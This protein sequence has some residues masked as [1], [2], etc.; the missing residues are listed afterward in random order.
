MLVPTYNWTMISDN[1]DPVTW[2]RFRNIDMEIFYWEQFDIFMVM[3]V[4]TY[5]WTMI[6]DNSEGKDLSETQNI[7]MEIFP[8]SNSGTE[9]N[10]WLR[11]KKQSKSYKYF[12][13]TYN[14]TMISENREGKDRVTW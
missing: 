8:F 2:Q 1:G 7:D 5:N 14:W 4:P 9:Q 13:S 6:S 10:D 3:L 12:K 11:E